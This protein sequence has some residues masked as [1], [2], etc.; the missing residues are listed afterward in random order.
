MPWG[1][2]KAVTL[3]INGDGTDEIIFSGYISN[4]YQ[5]ARLYDSY[6]YSANVAPRNC[7]NCSYTVKPYLGLI[8][9][10][11]DGTLKPESNYIWTG[12]NVIARIFHDGARETVGYAVNNRG[13]PFKLQEYKLAPVG[14]NDELFPFVDRETS[15][16]EGPLYG[17]THDDAAMRYYGGRMTIFKSDGKDLKAAGTITAGGTSAIIAADFAGE[18]MTLAKPTHIIREGDRSYMVV[19]QAPPYHVD[20][21][22]ADGT[23]LTTTPTNFSYVK[24][25]STSYQK[26]SVTSEKSNTKFDIHNTVE[27]IFAIDSDATQNI[28][29]GYKTAKNIYGLVK[30]VTGFIPGVDTKMKTVDGVV[31]KVTKFIDNCIDKVEYIKQGFDEAVN[32]TKTL[33]NV[34]TERLDS[35][36][37]VTSPQ[38]IWRYPIITVPAPEWGIDYT[39]IDKFVKKQDYL[40]FTLYDEVREST[41]QNDDCYQPT[42]E[43][44]NLFSYPS[45]VENIE[46]YADR[47]KVLSGLSTLEIGTTT[48]TQTMAFDQ[49]KTH[50]ETNSK[51]VTKGYL[52]NTLS[53]IDGIFGTDLANVPASETSPTYTRTES[54]GEKV[55][56]NLPNIDGAPLNNG[57]TYNYRAY[58]AE[59]GAITCG[60]A[61]NKF[62]T[63]KDLF[64][65][66]SIYSK[67]PDP[68]F[69]LPYK[70][71]LSD[72]RPTMPT[73]QV[74]TNRR[75][76]MGMRGVR[77]YAIDYNKYTSNRLLAGAKYRVE[78]PVYNA[79]FKNV[80]GVRVKLYWANDREESST[81][82]LIGESQSISMTGWK[83]D[84]NNKAWA[85]V[86][87]TP[88]MTRDGH[89]QLYAVIEYSGDEVHK[90][91][92]AEDPGGNNEGYFEFSVENAKSAKASSITSAF[93][94]ASEEKIIFPTITFNGKESWDAFY[95]EYIAGTE[96]PVSMEIVVTNEMS[97]TLPN[98]KVIA[99]YLD[100]E[101]WS[102]DQ[103]IGTSTFTKN[104]TLFPNETY[105]FDVTIEADIAD[106]M[107][108]VGKDNTFCT[109]TLPWLNDL[110]KAVYGDEDL[111]EFLESHDLEV[112]SADAYEE[113]ESADKYVQSVI[114]K[115]WTLSNDVPVFWR[116]DGIFDMI[117]YPES[118]DSEYV[119]DFEASAT[120]EEFTITWDPEDVNTVKTDTVNIVISTIAG[121]TLKSNY[122]FKVQISEDGENWEDKEGLIFNAD[123]D[124]S[125]T[126]TQVAGSSG[127]GCDSGFS[128]LGLGVMLSALIFRRRIK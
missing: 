83:D 66:Q 94:A 30:T 42:H 26:S 80:S 41:A 99:F 101:E 109:Y 89:Y 45:S 92:S 54:S 34:T 86:E 127:G 65:T 24:G 31:S 32:T 78:I 77:F 104:F 8:K 44:G 112:L 29:G 76:A 22:T 13:N 59:N 43:N 90:T 12:D 62:N 19:L 6:G 87:F 68:S 114:T 14:Q 38:N 16:T 93:S 117:S 95:D 106:K 119:K 35:I 111:I 85:R 84:G 60:F 128:A 55:T 23:K 17:G 21:I 115:T 47:Q 10:A 88:N 25:A 98:T 2:I 72:S 7:Q 116:I 36:Q 102:R 57:Y 75:E 18:G 4:L 126:E 108:E 28:I 107:R 69:V 70:F 124:S 20:N 120:K 71:T 81:K 33:S 51:K 125:T 27:T 64:S 37:Y 82:T 91:R 79:S 113:E 97:Y 100:A 15:I 56:F 103:T 122:S 52:S 46:G 63:N 105:K 73:F 96:G 39:S 58:V 118:D 9:I 11:S 53:L 1:G 49:V 40:T 3:D 67:Y 48:T 110:F 61:V 74:N 50:E 5:M 123:S 121:E